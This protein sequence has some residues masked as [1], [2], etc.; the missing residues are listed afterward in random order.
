M[1]NGKRYDYEGQCFLVH[2]LL[3]MEDVPGDS[4]NPLNWDTSNVTT[5]FNMFQSATVFNQDITNFDV[6]NV[7]F[8]NGMFK[9]QLRLTMANQPVLL[10]DH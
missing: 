6:S 9:M 10:E 4:N 3:I 2:Q 5:M 8:M 1:A 7:I